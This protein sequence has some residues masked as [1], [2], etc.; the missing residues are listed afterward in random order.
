MIRKASVMYVYR[1][2]FEEYKKR[3]D[4][5]WPEMEQVLKEHGVSN[6]GIFLHEPTAMLFAYLEAESEELHAQIAET[7]VCQRWWVYMQDI[8][9]TNPDHS[10]VSESLK[11]VFH[12]A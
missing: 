5:L 7:E 9:Q 6:Y 10:P 12:L 3:H 11:E 1:D 8:M 2:K 4:Q